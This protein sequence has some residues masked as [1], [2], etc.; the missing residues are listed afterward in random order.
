MRSVSVSFLRT[1]YDR[2]H[3]VIEWCCHGVARPPIAVVRRAESCALGYIR[4]YSDS[5]AFSYGERNV[6]YSSALVQRRSV[7]ISGW[8][9]RRSLTE[10]ISLS[11]IPWFFTR[12]RAVRSDR[13]CLSR[14]RSDTTRR[15]A[16]ERERE[17]G[18]RPA[19]VS[20]H[21]GEKSAGTCRNDR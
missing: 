13:A 2:R 4:P 19:S 20:R 15:R 10:Y 14:S 16:R 17:K 8:G 18:E 11:V 9:F 5:L 12:W 6:S 21:T 7:R 1:I 3:D